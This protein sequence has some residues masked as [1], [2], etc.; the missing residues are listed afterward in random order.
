MNKLVAK[1][2]NS[3][4]SRLTVFAKN[5]KRGVNVG[6][7][8]KAVGEPA[9]TGCRSTVATEIEGT[10]AWN[11]LKAAA[12]ANGWTLTVAKDRSSFT[13]IPL[14][15]PKTAEPAAEPKKKSSKAA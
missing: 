13:T 12:I 2:A 11:T 3:E 10:E 1:F 7:S 15:N 4:G 14:A 8:L 9:Q 6:A 5:G